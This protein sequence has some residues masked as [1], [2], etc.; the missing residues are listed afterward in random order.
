MIQDKYA[1]E[2]RWWMAVGIVCTMALL[3]ALLVILPAFAAT[4]TDAPP[5]RAPQCHI[6]GY[7]YGTADLEEV[8]AMIAIPVYC[9]IEYQRVERRMVF[10]SPRWQVEINIPAA[11]GWMPFAYTWGSDR[12]FIG[13]EDVPVAAGPREG[14]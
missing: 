13:P 12:A 9:R 3:F 5:C 14:I 8:A 6:R 2:R 1:V 10:T 7:V 4:Q 11:G